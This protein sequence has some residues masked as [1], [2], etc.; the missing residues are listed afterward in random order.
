VRGAPAGQHRQRG[1]RALPAACSRQSRP[2]TSSRATCTRSPRSESGAPAR[3]GRHAQREPRTA[4]GSRWC[5]AASNSARALCRIT[6]RLRAGRRERRGAERCAL[7]H[8]AARRGRGRGR[9]RGRKRGRSA[10]GHGAA[11]GRAHTR[12]GP[13]RCPRCTAA[14]GAG[15]RGTCAARRAARPQHGV[16]PVVHG[17]QTGSGAHSDSASRRVVSSGWLP[18]SGAACAARPRL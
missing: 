3:P 6:S 1:P 7:G 17:E 8:G 16:A 13:A 2:V 5:R 18:G 4:S 14:S 10:L 9:G 15:C 11:C 12:A